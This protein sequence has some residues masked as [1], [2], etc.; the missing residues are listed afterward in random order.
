MVMLETPPRK[1]TVPVRNAAWAKQRA[2]AEPILTEK[3]RAVLAGL[4]EGRET[5]QVS[6][7]LGIAIR[8]FDGRLK[9]ICQKLGA[10][11]RTHAV[12]I[13]L[14]RDLIPRVP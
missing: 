14:S 3:Q 4:A 12:A 11:N 1:R 6:H 13:A 10:N 9:R 2:R 7:D 5:K 8:T